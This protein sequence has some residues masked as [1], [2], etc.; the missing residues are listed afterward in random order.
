MDLEQEYKREDFP[1][2]YLRVVDVIGID[3]AVLL[4]KE[5]GGTPMYVPKLERPKAK[6]KK[7][8]IQADFRAG[9]GIRKLAR[10]YRCSARWITYCVKGIKREK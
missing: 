9:E 8:A 2:Y 7:R 6:V 5:I 3:T 4:C 10:K 1:A